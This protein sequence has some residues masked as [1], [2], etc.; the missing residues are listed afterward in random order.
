MSPNVVDLGLSVVDR[1]TDEP[2][3]GAVIEYE[4]V[5]SGK[6]VRDSLVTAPDGRCVL[7]GVPECGT[8][9]LHKVGCYGYA[10]TTDVSI[11]VKSAISNPD[12]STIRLTPLKES[13]TYFVKN[14]CR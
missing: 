13:F 7:E 4:Y 3:A 9:K 8:I 2:L 1:E 14:K 11:S 5:L 6:D 10:D 12:S